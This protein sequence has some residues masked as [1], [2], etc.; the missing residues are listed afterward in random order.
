MNKALFILIAL[1]FLIVG[2]ASAGVDVP[3]L[4]AGHVYDSD[5]DPIQG[6]SVTVNCEHNGV[7]YTQYTLSLLDGS[8]QV[9]YFDNDECWV[10]DTAFVS[11]EYNGNT[12]SGT[13]PVCWDG[14]QCPIPIAIVD[15]TI[16]ELT[17]LGA[18]IVV[19]AGVGIIAYKRKE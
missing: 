10:G 2:F 16:P 18:M 15:I 19:L 6:A 17:M 7:N 4:V 12:G 3:V 8:Y 14:E 13:G 11:A 5:A 1:S 9:V